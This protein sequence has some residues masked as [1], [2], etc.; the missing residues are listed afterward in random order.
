[1]T[2]V[3]LRPRAVAGLDKSPPKTRTLIESLIDELRG[4]KIP[5]HTKKL[6]GTK[7]GYR[8]RVGK[9]RVLF[10]FENK[11]ID[12]VDIFL[13]KGPEDYRRRVM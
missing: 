9:W 13:K 5:M 10:S 12:I 8:T 4:G 7:T 3:F 1:M 6:S 2:L 11:E